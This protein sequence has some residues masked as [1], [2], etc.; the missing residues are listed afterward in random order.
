MEE[1]TPLR[2]QEQLKELFELLERNPVQAYQVRRMADY[3]DHMEQAVS[4]ITEELKG[5]RTQVEHLEERG[6]KQ[7]VLRGIKTAEDT[8][9]TI[10]GQITYIKKRFVEQAKTTV[11]L[12]KQRGEAVLLL[13]I[14]AMHLPGILHK[15]QENLRRGQTALDKSIDSLSNIG[16]ELHAVKGHVEN[17]GNALKGKP[18]KEMQPRNTEQGLIFQTQKVLYETCG[19]LSRMEQRTGKVL[20]DFE[21]LGKKRESVRENLQEIQARGK[22]TLSVPKPPRQMYR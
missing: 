12:C 19:R 7:A 22:E 2:E 11:E 5:L 18:G 20:S 17:I 15:I 3:I 14:R 10:K 9:D 6:I 21:Q 13:S 8:A 4:E 16:E 1:K